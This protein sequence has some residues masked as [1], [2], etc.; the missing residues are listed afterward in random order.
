MEKFDKYADKV[1]DTFEDLETAVT[2]EKTYWGVTA[3]AWKFASAGGWPVGG[4]G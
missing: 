4:W 1:E 2:V 3:P